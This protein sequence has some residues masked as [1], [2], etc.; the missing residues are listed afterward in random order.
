MYHYS[1]VKMRCRN[2]KMVVAFLLFYL[3]FTCTLCQLESLMMT[4]TWRNSCFETSTLVSETMVSVAH[5]WKSAGFF[6]WL[7]LLVLR[8]LT[9]LKK[10]RCYNELVVEK[11]KSIWM[12]WIDLCSHY[13]SR[14]DKVSHFSKNGMW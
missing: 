12:F 2:H 14:D 6:C 10:D 8:S 13:D 4:Q 5:L 7:H 3:V 9:A 11:S 1:Y